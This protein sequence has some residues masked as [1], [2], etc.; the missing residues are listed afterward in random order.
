MATAT[1]HGGIEHLDRPTVSTAMQAVAGRLSGRAR[2]SAS[3]DRRRPPQ[4]AGRR[5]GIERLV[6]SVSRRGRPNP[7]G[8]STLYA[9]TPDGVFKLQVGR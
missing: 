6:P 8:F 3:T 2:P 9:G 5:A 4:V 1:A 7:L